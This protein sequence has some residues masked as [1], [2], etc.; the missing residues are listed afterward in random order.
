MSF[1]L[2][3]LV[4]VI[5]FIKFTV[6][7]IATKLFMKFTHDPKQTELEVFLKSIY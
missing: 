4:L 7:K 3:A 6:K 1:R 5:C 2:W